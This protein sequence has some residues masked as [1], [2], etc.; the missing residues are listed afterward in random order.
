MK[1]CLLFFIV[2]LCLFT[3]GPAQPGSATLLVAPELPRTL[4]DTTYVPPAGNTIN[5]PSGD[6][7][8][9]AITNAQPGDTIVLQAGATY[10]APPDGFTL[11]N[12]SGSSWIVIRTSN[13]AALP[14]EGTRVGPSH[15]AAMARI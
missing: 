5:V 3:F 6:N 11:P 4:L 14:A 8:Q 9:T 12:K 13:L 7:L 15:G 10:I 1:N 2:A